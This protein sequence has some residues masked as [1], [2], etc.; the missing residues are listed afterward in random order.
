[1]DI[2][3]VVIPVPTKTAREAS[4]LVLFASPGDTIRKKQLIAL[5]EG[6]KGVVQV[7]SPFSGVVKEVRVKVG[8]RVAA[9]APILTL[10]R[11]EP[12]GRYSVESAADARHLPALPVRH[13]SR[14]LPASR[15]PTLSAFQRQIERALGGTLTAPASLAAADFWAHRETF[16][17]GLARKDLLVQF[18]LETTPAHQRRPTARYYQSLQRL[19]HPLVVAGLLLMFFLWQAAVALIALGL[20]IHFSAGYLGRRDHNRGHRPV[21]QPAEYAPSETAMAKLCAQYILGMV[22]LI[23][24]AGR[25]QWPDYPSSVLTG[26]RTRISGAESRTRP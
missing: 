20:T 26:K 4:I 14:N 24:T 8:T 1:M 10:D 12:R 23:S 15:A 6:D 16:S 21:A 2:D 11:I 7:S 19:A 18:V 22:A 9:G 5:L 13:A 17:K 3:E 25:A